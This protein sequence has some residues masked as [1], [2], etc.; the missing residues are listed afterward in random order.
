MI[1][2]GD[3]GATKINLA[4][5]DDSD[6][7]LRVVEERSFA[8]RDYSGLEEIGREFLSSTTLQ[9]KTASFG[10]ACPL[11]GG[12]CKM[13]N[14]PW[15][16]DQISLR[17]ALQLEDVIL[18][19]DLEATGYGIATLTP[20]KFVTINEGK[21]REHANVALIA[22]GT[23]LGEAVLCSVGGH[24]HVSAS[25]GGHTDFAPCDEDQIALLRYLIEEFG[26]VSYERV[27][28]GPGLVNIYNFLRETES[29][30][31]TWLAE[32]ISASDDP[33][34]VISETA[35]VETS[36][37]C[38]RALDIFVSV[39]GA[40]AGNLALK[41]LATGGLYV[42]GGI[43]PKILPLLMDGRFLRAFTDK[44]RY[45]ELI[46]DIP[47]KVIMEPKTALQGAAAF[48]LKRQRR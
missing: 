33:A 43:A 32:R 30:E 42:G 26:H 40:E 36:G 39:Y 7:G 13:P 38:F 48:G 17:D 31:D 12:R 24:Y 25:E 4:I 18:L 44:G 27:V 6:A 20:D 37:I 15:I 9:V 16:I 5:F 46:Q 35:L 19:N 29:V 23:G 1:L 21:A 22:A 34:A 2:S 41:A 47:V 11:Q 45:R 10:V 28:S 8:S 3:V 14:L